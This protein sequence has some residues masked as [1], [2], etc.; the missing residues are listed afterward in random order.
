MGIFKWR[1]KEVTLELQKA[2]Q[3][4]VPALEEAGDPLSSRGRGWGAPAAELGS[5]P[6][7]P[8]PHPPPRGGLETTARPHCGWGSPGGWR[9]SPSPP[10]QVASLC[11]RL[12]LVSEEWE[13]LGPSLGPLPYLGGSSILPSSPGLLWGHLREGPSLPFP[14]HPHLSARPLQGSLPPARTIHPT[15]QS[16][17][18]CFRLPSHLAGPA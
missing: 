12:L 17:S 14:P 1:R 5:G 9:P 18:S 8:T 13:G 15:S 11:T 3:R 10:I 7:R 16:P 6:T 2:G 4:A